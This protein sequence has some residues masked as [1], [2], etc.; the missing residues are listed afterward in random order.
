M[1]FSRYYRHKLTAQ[2]KIIYDDLVAGMKNR[3]YEVQTNYVSSQDVSIIIHAVNFDNPQL[4]YV[5][6][7][8]IT[9]I[10]SMDI[11]KILVSYLIDEGLQRK[12]DQKLKTVTS[13]ILKNVVG[14]TMKA[15]S[16]I[17][18]D[19]LVCNCKYE[20]YNDIPNASHSIVGAL[21]NS[22]GVCDGYAKAY[23]YLADFIKMRSIVV[24]G[25]GIHPDGTAGGHAWNIVMLNKQ[26]FHVDV[27]FDLLFAGKYCSRAYYL[28]TTKEILYDHSIDP[29]FDMPEC[30]VESQVLQVVSGTAELIDF[31]S[32][33]Y[34]SR[35]THS[36]VRLTKGFSK[37]KLFTMIKEKMAAKDVGWYSQID[38]LWYGDKSRT[39][40][41]CWK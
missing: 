38:S 9:V 41:V 35:V 4:Y 6:F 26:C 24:V 8:R 31:L 15:A 5:D 14:K 30:S 7:S 40:F 2:Q 23:K 29:T 27:T 16:L 3:I 32:S 39:L 13:E 10:Q 21:I 34:Q 19:W 18:H 22:K 11:S 37:Q 12:I 20:E 17:L 28:L 33:Q 25:K 36:E 1:T